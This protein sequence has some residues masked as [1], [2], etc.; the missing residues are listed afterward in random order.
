M[1][2]P[3]SASSVVRGELLGHLF[4]GGVLVGDAGKGGESTRAALPFTQLGQ[5]DRSGLAL[6]AALHGAGHG[7]LDLAEGV[8][9]GLLVHHLEGRLDLGVHDGLVN[10]AVRIDD[11]LVVR[12]VVGDLVALVLGQGYLVGEVLG[13]VDFRV[14]GDARE[15]V[16]HARGRSALKHLHLVERDGAPGGAA[17][18]VAIGAAVDVEAH[19][20]GLLR[21]VAQGD[22]LRLCGGMVVVGVGV[23][24][25]A[26][27]GLRSAPSCASWIL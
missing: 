9:L 17:I 5:D 22:G 12:A 1:P 21:G 26:L 24:P 8:R 18:R 14:D 3:V 10:G 11:L 27:R 2:R 13:G 15:H 7:D 23:Y 25:A 4:K 19:V 20:A 16:A 6:L